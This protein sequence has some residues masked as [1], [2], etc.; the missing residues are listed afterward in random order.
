MFTVSS[1]VEIQRPPQAVFAFA[2]DYANDPLW[3]A[4]VLGMV[5]DAGAPPAVG[6]RTRETLRSMGRTAVTVGEITDFSPARTAFRSVSG[7]VPCDGS[8]EFA[9]SAGG[10]LFTYTLRLHPAG[11]LRAIEPLLRWVFG[12]QVRAD[13]RRLK[14]LL[15][16]R[17]P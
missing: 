4:G 15:E 12:R 14:H 1:S 8:R 11:P 16:T 17:G 6:T 2:G 3:R 10:T 13:L 9:A 5:Y 7:P